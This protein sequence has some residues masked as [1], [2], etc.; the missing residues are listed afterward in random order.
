MP[1]Y[2]WQVSYTKEGTKGVL[3]D[4]GTGRRAAVEQLVKEQGGSIEAFYYAFGP[5]DVVIIADLPDHATA[6]AI[7]MTVTASGAATPRTTVLLSPEELD[8]ATQRT[9]NYRPPG[10]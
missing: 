2:L 9:V 5:D 8:E 7:A 6:A 10:S 3:Q 4:G 1:K